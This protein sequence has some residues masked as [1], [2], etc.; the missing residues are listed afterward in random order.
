MRRSFNDGLGGNPSGRGNC[1][2]SLGRLESKSFQVLPVVKHFRDRRESM[3][4]IRASYPASE[5]SAL[6]SVPPARSPSLGS[7]SAIEV[8]AVY[9]YDYA[10]KKTPAQGFGDSQNPADGEEVNLTVAL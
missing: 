9:E 10:H 6:P 4:R 3:T 1:H 8:L 2:T 7:R 5:R